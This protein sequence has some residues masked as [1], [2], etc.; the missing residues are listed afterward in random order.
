MKKKNLDFSEPMFYNIVYYKNKRKN[1]IHIKSEIH[2]GGN[3]A[4]QYYY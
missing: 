3:Y 2:I 4:R 1:I